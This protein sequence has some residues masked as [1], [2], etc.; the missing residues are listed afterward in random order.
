MTYA[1]RLRAAREGLVTRLATVGPL[2]VLD[3]VEAGVVTLR[4]SAGSDR[5]VT[6]RALGGS[7]RGYSY[8][9]Q[10]L[11]RQID[12]SWAVSIGPK[13]F[14]YPGHAIWFATTLLNSYG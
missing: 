12:G 5:Q 11:V 3:D 6:V 1:D 14:S 9:V 4:Q 7:V 2:W 13:S 8:Q 10:L